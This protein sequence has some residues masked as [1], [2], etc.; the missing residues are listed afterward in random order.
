MDKQDFHAE[1]LEIFHARPDLMALCIEITQ[2][3]LNAL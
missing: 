3:L 1:S 2:R